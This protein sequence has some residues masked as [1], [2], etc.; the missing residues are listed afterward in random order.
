MKNIK[1]LFAT[2]VAVAHFNSDKTIRFSAR[3]IN[4]AF[5]VTASDTVT[6]AIIKTF[7]I[8]E[9]KDAEFNDRL[10]W[11]I[12]EKRNNKIRCLKKSADADECLKALNAL[13]KPYGS[14]GFTWEELI[15]VV[16]S[17]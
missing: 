3:R 2:I 14:Y 16:E 12:I 1:D 15:S 13:L 6:E 7:F 11:T 10:R 9:L 17:R 8:G 5:E 4:S